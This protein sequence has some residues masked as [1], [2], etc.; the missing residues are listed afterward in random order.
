MIKKKKILIYEPYPF[1]MIA[2]NLRTLKYI[3]K[4]INPKKFELIIILP[5]KTDLIKKLSKYNVK[6]I[7]LDTPYE[8]KVYGQKTLNSS[9]LSK[10]LTTLSLVK[11]S[12][13]LRKL[14]LEQKIDSIYCNGIRS[15]LTLC[16]AS[17]ITNRPILWY[18]KG[19][20]ENNILD[21]LAFFFS[22]K[23]IFYS[24]SN[25]KD[26]YPLLRYLFKKKI[27]IIPTGLD[28]NKIEKIKETDSSYILKE[29]NMENK[30]F[31][32][33]FFGQIYQPK[34]L[35]FLIEAIKLSKAYN[36]N[37]KL[38]IVGDIFLIEHQK[39]LASL[40]KKISNLQLERNVKFTGWR[41]DS[42]NVMNMMDIII[43]PSL[44]EGFS[45]SVLEAMALGK[46]VISSNVGG[47]RDTI[48]E[49]FN[50]FLVEAKNSKVIAE[51]I[52]Y[53]STR[54]KER[55]RIGNNAYLTIKKKHNIE[56][57]IILLGMEFEKL[58][59]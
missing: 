42:L 9:I 19:Q 39:Y 59:Q 7:V 56:D 4:Y 13:K 28:L 10:F 24:S 2:G 25:S 51:K 1:D 17:I 55:I 20:L 32:I 8:L 31:N 22:K 52:I 50:G 37:L 12:F 5:F 21:R 18:V 3:I 15:V 48:E 14:I 54:P 45:R 23:I 36:N 44:A 46:T 33:G 30:D 6:I 11:Y 58:N 40:K 34:G 29:L 26:K 53:L 16:I 27:A 49:N 41:D 38:F 35:D 57:K 43:H 47:E